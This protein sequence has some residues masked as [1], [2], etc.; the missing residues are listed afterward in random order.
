[1]DANASLLGTM[2][3]YVARFTSSSLSAPYGIDQTV[4]DVDVKAWS[5]LEDMLADDDVDVVVVATPSNNHVDIAAAALQAKKH[6]VVDK[7]LAVNVADVNRLTK[8]AQVNKRAI[9]CFQ[10]R[11]FDGD[12]LTAQALLRS[13]T[14]GHVS[15]IEVAFQKGVVSRSWSLASTV[16]CGNCS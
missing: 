15:N 1:M 8:L 9:T 3:A 6:V 7:P 13:G 14:L 11:R 4:P 5:T 2:P 12:F 10:N 16:V